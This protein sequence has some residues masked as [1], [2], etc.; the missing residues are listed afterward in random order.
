MMEGEEGCVWESYGRAIRMS[1]GK[2]LDRMGKG[3]ENSAFGA[4][5][6]EVIH[7]GQRGSSSTTSNLVRVGDESK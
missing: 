6:G 7:M 5:G 4:G 3:V 1:L 2:D